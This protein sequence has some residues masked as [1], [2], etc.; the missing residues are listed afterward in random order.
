MPEHMATCFPYDLFMLIHSNSS[1]LCWCDQDSCWTRLLLSKEVD[2]ISG[3]V[4]D[5]PNSPA[6]SK[7]VS[8][9]SHPIAALIHVRSI[10]D[11]QQFD[12][13]RTCQSDRFFLGETSV[14]VG[15]G[16]FISDIPRFPRLRMSQSDFLPGSARVKACKGGGT[17][18]SSE[19]EICREGL[20]GQWGTGHNPSIIP[21]C[22][23]R[24]GRSDNHSNVLFGQIIGDLNISDRPHFRS[25]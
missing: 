8:F 17:H 25:R 3:G 23:E 13:V 18:N 11:A 7:E 22:R 4:G 21:I 14:G 15:P 20:F 5:S 24:S 10:M 19:G 12:K 6:H 1:L 2:S 9:I 16:S